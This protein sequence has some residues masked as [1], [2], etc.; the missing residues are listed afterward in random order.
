MDTRINLANPMHYS[1]P[2]RFAGETF[3]DFHTF[4]AFLMHHGWVE[5]QLCQGPKTRQNLYDIRRDLINYVNIL[6]A[7]E[8]T[9]PEEMELFGWESSRG[10]RIYGPHELTYD[11]FNL[12]IYRF[13]YGELIWRAHHRRFTDGLLAGQTNWTWFLEWKAIRDNRRNH[14]ILLDARTANEILLSDPG[15]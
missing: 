6:V 2:R 15:D 7:S 11:E 4:I 10:A 9:E 3:T 8:R 1:P 14:K 12:C 5:L 13:L